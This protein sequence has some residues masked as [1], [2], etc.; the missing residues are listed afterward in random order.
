[1]S[2]G[3]RGGYELIVTIVSKGNADLVLD[4]AKQAGAGGGTIMHGRGAGKHETQKFLGIRVE[5][6]KELVLTAV[7]NEDVDAVLDA[8]VKAGKLD[9]PGHGIAFTM[10]ISRITGLVTPNES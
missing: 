1:M 10:P 7:Q 5:P 3:D 8:I 9:E 2:D 6:E 4:A